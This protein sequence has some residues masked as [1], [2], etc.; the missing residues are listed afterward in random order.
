MVQVSLEVAKPRARQ[1]KAAQQPAE[2]EPQSGPLVAV[3]ERGSVPKKSEN[4][5]AVD[6]SVVCTKD[7][8]L[9]AERALTWR[10]FCHLSVWFGRRTTGPGTA[11]IAGIGEMIP[12]ETLAV[13][14]T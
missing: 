14:K 7:A 11:G 3:G 1:G 10:V 13:L 2:Q 6:T 9:E 5:S 12:A 8:G 4:L